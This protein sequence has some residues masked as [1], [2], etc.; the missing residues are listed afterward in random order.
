[1]TCHWIDDGIDKGNIISQKKFRI[2]SYHTA[3]DVYERFTYEAFKLFEIVYSKILS[4]KKIRSKTVK[5]KTK[6]RKKH[7]PNYG[8]INW[9]WNGKRILN[10]IRSMTYEPFEPPS[11]NLGKK[12]YFIVDQKLIKKNFYKSPS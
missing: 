4:Q 3:R 12:K 10:F 5:A 7:L 11:F 6:Y 1:M 9:N 8:Q 2:K